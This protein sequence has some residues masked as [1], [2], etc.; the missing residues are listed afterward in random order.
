M[1]MNIKN[2][3]VRDAIWFLAFRE[4]RKTTCVKEEKKEGCS[5]DCS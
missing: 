3:Y 2:P 1:K 5:S 4:R